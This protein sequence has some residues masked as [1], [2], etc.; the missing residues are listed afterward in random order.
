METYLS[1][2]KNEV[3]PETD[4]VLYI[5][6]KRWLMTLSDAYM[7][8]SLLN[9]T[10]RVG[11][12]YHKGSYLERV[13]APSPDARIAPILGIDRIKWDDNEKTLTEKS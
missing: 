5:G 6:D 4:V 10:S 13:I 11:S 7:I 8:A 2:L 12:E 9:S 3:H 1:M